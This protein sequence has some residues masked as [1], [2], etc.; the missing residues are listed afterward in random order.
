MRLTQH[1]CIAHKTNLASRSA[2]HHSACLCVAVS[3]AGGEGQL[4]RAELARVNYLNSF[5]KRERPEFGVHD[6]PLMVK[7]LV[8][9]ALIWSNVRSDLSPDPL[10]WHVACHAAETQAIVY[11][12]VRGVLAPGAQWAKL[13]APTGGSV[14]DDMRAAAVSMQ[15]GE[16]TPPRTPAAGEV[17]SAADVEFLVGVEEDGAA[18]SVK[19]KKR[20]GKHEL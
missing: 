9:S 13:L 11:I 18:S 14:L 7:P 12:T 2:V 4:S 5:C 17:R 6:D 10:A 15:A 19:H 20:A 1:L 8:G 3:G 16:G